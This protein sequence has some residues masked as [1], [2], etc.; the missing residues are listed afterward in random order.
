MECINLPVEQPLVITR[1][2]QRITVTAFLTA[3]PGNIKLG[4]NAPREV[5]VDREEVHY[6]KKRN[7]SKQDNS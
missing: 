1:G 7:D 6:L 2:A 3:E 5:S 4:I